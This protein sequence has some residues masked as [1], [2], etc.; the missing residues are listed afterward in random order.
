MQKPEMN[1][2]LV[3]TKILFENRVKN[4][5]F[6]ACAPQNNLIFGKTLSEMASHIIFGL[7]LLILIFNSLGNYSHLATV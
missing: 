3:V 5:H 4:M 1:K 2:A 7:Y 6:L